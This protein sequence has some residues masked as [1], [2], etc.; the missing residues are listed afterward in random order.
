MFECSF[1][2]ITITYP[3]LTPHLPLTGRFVGVHVSMEG[4]IFNAIHNA[5]KMNSNAFA[6]FL[7]SQRSWN[8]K[9]LD[10]I[11]ATIFRR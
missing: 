3:T 9:P 5:A 8:F 6:L 11:D 7:K 2:F 10:D 4:G 1:L